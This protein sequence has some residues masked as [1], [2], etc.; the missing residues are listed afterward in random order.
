[1]PENLKSFVHHAREKG[2]DHGTIRDLLAAAGWKE[3]DI[4]GAIA[5]ESLDVPVPKP[6][7]SRNARDA[8]LYLLTFAALYVTVSSVV[9]LFFTYLDYVYPDPAWGEWNSESALSPVRYAIAAIAVGL[10]LFLLLTSVVGRL[11]QREPDGQSH[12][13][14]T[15]L[16][17][18]TLF[19][20]SAI[21][22]GDLITPLYFF[23]DGALTTR[24]VLKVVVLLVIAGLVLAY[25]LSSLRSLTRRGEP[26]YARWFAAIAGCLLVAISVGLGFE[27]AGSPFS[28]RLQRLDD[29]RVED[30]R[31]IHRAVQQMVTKPDLNSNTVK[32]VRALPK[33]LDE[34]AD[35]QR[36]RQSGVK[37]N[38]ADPQTGEK[39]GY[40]VTG[41]KTYELSATFD[42]ARERK[43]DLFW[44]HPA[45]KHAFKFN[46]ESPP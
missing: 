46:A 23:L 9:A 30:L 19:L 5:G 3:R 14:G 26:Q 42:L 7:G 25:Y 6:V 33:T 20:A 38:L 35:F 31:A 44:N 13:V 12:P 29:R 34:I 16:T 15:W 4:A 11:V 41:E 24:F 43:Q 39:Y 18:L 40:T 8:F 2:L 32:V 21:A 27:M 37:L 36:S 28:V 17:Y 10:P 45:G 22:V 1:M